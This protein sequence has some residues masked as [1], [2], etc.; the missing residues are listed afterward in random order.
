[1]NKRNALI[2]L[3][4]MVP[5]FLGYAE[6][7]NAAESFL[8]KGIS[9]FKAE[10]YEEAIQFLIKAREQQ[11]ESSMAAYYLGMTYNQMGEYR[12]ASKHLRDAIRLTPSVKEAYPELIQ[13]LSN[14]NELKE[15]KD[16][17]AQAEQKDVKPGQIT[18]L[19]GLIL[20]KEGKNSEAIDA[21]K[22]AKRMDSSLNQASDM[23]I[24]V[25]LTKQR[26]FAEAKE[27]LR[28]IISVDPLSEI[29]TY[30]REYEIAFDQ[31]LKKYKSWWAS[32]GIAYQYDDN[33]LLKPSQ[34]IPDVLIRGQRDSSVITTLGFRYNPRLSEPWFF[35]AQYNFYADT[36]FSQHKVDFLYQTVSLTP[37]YQ[38]PKGAIT[39]PVA[40]S[41]VWLD[42]DQYM[43]VALANPTL[44]IIL[45][46]NH[47][48]QFSMGYMRREILHDPLDRYENRDGNILTVSP[49]YIYSF[50]N[51]KGLFMLKYEFS[52]DNTEGKNWENT[53][54]QIN[55]SLLL[56]V[57]EKLSFTISGEMLL[58]D[59]QHTH[60]FF[61]MKRSDRTYYGAAGMRWEVLNGLNLNLQYSHTHAD[62]NISVYEY[63]RNI[64][65]VGF[66]YIF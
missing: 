41:H 12:Q 51:G 34:S 44:S 48:A 8:D 22:K 55:L 62:S 47:I 16:W 25:A 59:Y 3:L 24:A 64:Y 29:G 66:E 61:G 31:G 20:L 2:L 52:S 11:P 23:Q 58:Q 36:H 32:A 38:F 10:N 7:L 45:L 15:A 60:T 57:I 30:A 65:T 50:K 40:Y 63:K 26:R 1:M 17:I 13:A 35:N 42:R 54:N 21:F 5:I 39:L 27:T 43:A 14:L 37:G 53:G 49:G 33:V 28:A 19:K 6:N 46:P 9:E 18:Y 4:L 56:P